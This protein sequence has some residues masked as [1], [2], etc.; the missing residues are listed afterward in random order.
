MVKS[1][2]IIVDRITVNGRFFILQNSGF[3]CLNYRI[4]DLHIPDGLRGH[5]GHRLNL[6]HLELDAH[7][8]M[9]SNAQPTVF[10]HLK[11]EQFHDTDC[12]LIAA[13]SE[14]L[15]ELHIR[16]NPLIVNVIAQKHDTFEASLG[17]QFWIFQVAVDKVGK[18]FV[19]ARIGRVVDEM[20]GLFLALHFLVKVY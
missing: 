14:A 16:Y 6:R 18:G 17:G 10:G 15:H 8:F 1:I 19:A 3:F 12:L 11:T 4:T 9:E 13:Q 20:F 5:F 2:E 7:V